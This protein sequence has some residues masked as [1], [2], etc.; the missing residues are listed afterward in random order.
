MHRGAGRA[1][2]GGREQ[3]GKAQVQAVRR[4]HLR[5]Q[6]R[7][8]PDELGHRAARGVFV[9]LARRGNLQQPAVLEHGHAVGHHQCFFL[10]V[11]DQQR[12]GVEA[13]LNGADLVAQVAA[14][15]GVQ[16][17]QRLVE[18]QRARVDGQ[19]AR[20]RHALL[21]PARKLCNRALRVV[22]QPHDV[23]QVLRALAALCR[24]D[25]AQLEAVG[26]VVEHAQVR[27]QCI[28]LEHHAEVALVH[29]RARHVFAA[30]QD[31]ARVAGLQPRHQLEQCRLARAAGPDHR[32]Q[33]AR[34]HVERHVVQ[35]VRAARVV[36]ADV[37][38]EEAHRSYARCFTMRGRKKGRRARQ[39]EEDHRGRAGKARGAIEGLQQHHRVGAVLE[40]R[41]Q[42]RHAELAHRNGGH[43]H[44]PADQA[45]AQAGQHDAG[46]LLPARGAERG[47]GLF[48]PAQVQ[49]AQV[50]QQRVR[51]VGQRKNGVRRDQQR[52][53]AQP[54]RK[55]GVEDDHV[56]EGHGDG[57]H[58]HR[59]GAHDARRQ[60]A[61][62]PGAVV[63]RIG[64]RQRQ[65]GVDGAGRQGHHEAADEGLAK[66]RVEPQVDVPLARDARGQQRVGPVAAKAADQQQG[67]GQ[68]QVQAVD[69]RDA[70]NQGCLQCHGHP[71]YFPDALL[72]AL[73]ACRSVHRILG[74]KT[75]QLWVNVG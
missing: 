50:G 10:V 39:H 24:V 13:L 63:Q 35:A 59:R 25:L 75:G 36:V 73:K 42:V 33:F 41:E 27:E 66:R 71:A 48:E 32:D 15:A 38:Q 37:V 30:E 45:L 8:E 9:N 6:D 58:R 19:C 62:A 68:Q 46:E 52:H 23:E 67:D 16:R 20:Q 7:R 47:C 12:G 29:R 49:V 3:F 70:A 60:A 43:H 18:Q 21:L 1:V 2:A 55:V 61:A 28:A 56:A 31:A 74:S 69:E 17:R 5:G 26:H 4:R 65:H 22:A 34:A 44:Q 11:R 40:A 72:S 64:Q 51:E 53:R 57:R 14:H 54:G